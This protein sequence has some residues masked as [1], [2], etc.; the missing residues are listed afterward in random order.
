MLL[1]RLFKN[2]RVGGIVFVILLAILSYFVSF[3]SP[4]GQVDEQGMPMYNLIFGQIDHIRVLNYILALAI[5]LLI[6]LVLVRMNLRFTLIDERTFMPALFYLIIVNA[7]PSLHQVNPMLVGALFYLLSF[8]MILNAHDEG[9]DS[10]K[11]FNAFLVL[12]AGVLFYAKLIWFLPVLWLVLLTI[13]AV[14][15]RELIF[16]MV[17]GIFVGLLTFTTFWIILDDLDGLAELLRSQLSFG[18]H[19]QPV[20]ISI[21]LFMGFL[22]LLVIIASGFIITR[23]QARKI[24]I[25]NIY[26]V[27]FFMFL[28]SIIFFFLISGYR[29]GTIYYMAIPVTYLFTN[30]FQHG[31]SAFLKEI[32]IWILMGLMIYVQLTA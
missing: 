8:I 26:Q 22:L 29:T 14:T 24:I 6:C 17:A 18:G 9:P 11:I 2:N 13:R 10:L 30:Y 31:G 4:T 25:R 20:R 32:F 19:L 5:H 21:Y 15:P 7:F 3:L 23:F 12:F 28:F 1:L 16:P 27:L